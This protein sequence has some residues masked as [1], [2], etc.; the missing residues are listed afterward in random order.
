[1]EKRKRTGPRLKIT[2]F[3]T[4]AQQCSSVRQTAGETAVMICW[5]AK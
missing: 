2:Q 1:V 3:V 4:R 5:T